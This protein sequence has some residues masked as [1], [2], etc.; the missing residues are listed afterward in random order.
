V[1]LAALA[2][3]CGGNDSTDQSSTPS[4]PRPAATK[5]Q[6]I[7]RSN[8]FCEG[9]RDYIR[10]KLAIHQE[11]Q[12][13]KMSEAELFASAAGGFILPT[14]QFW[15][16]DIISLPKPAGD[17]PEIED[18]LRTIQLTV[19]NGLKQRIPS[20]H[21]LS[22]IFHRSNRLMERYGINSCVVNDAFFRG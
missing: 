8:A 13:P 10:E 15:Y 17:I 20:M 12:G 19:T 2:M 21:Q 7:A 9:S 1:I 5:E 6:F 14:L 3:G 4:T 18:I 16:D 22:R 11:E